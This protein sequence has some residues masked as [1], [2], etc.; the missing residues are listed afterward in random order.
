[1]GE[2]YGS[3][4]P[5]GYLFIKKTGSPAE[6]S[7]R[8]VLE[9]FLAHF[10]D[11]HHLRVHFTLSDK[12]PDEIAACHHV[13]S[14]AKH[15][16]CFWHAFRAIKRRLAI[17]RRQPAHYNVSQATKEFP[18][19]DKNFLPYAQRPTDVPVREWFII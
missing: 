17:L 14:E 6:R 5:L 1:M 18:L 12:D 3:G 19:I 2:A 13:F 4:V 9:Q 15:Q 16:L 11:V 8:K 10:R 7:K